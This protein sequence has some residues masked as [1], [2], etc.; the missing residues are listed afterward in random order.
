MKLKLLFLFL[1]F[2]IKSVFAQAPFITTWEVTADDLDIRIPANTFDGRVF[3][4][5]INF[6]DGTIVN[7]V[8]GWITHTY[9]TPGIYTVEIS[10]VFP[11]IITWAL[12]SGEANQLKSI[13]QWGDIEWETMSTAFAFC[14]NMV[15]NAT[16]APDLSQTTSLSSMFW[17]AESMNSDINH[18]DVSTITNMSGLFYS[19]SSFNQPLNN[20][21]V[22]NVVSM[23]RMFGRDDVSSSNDDGMFNQPLNN[24][25]VTNVTDM[26]K[27][28]YGNATFNQ[29]ISMWNV[30]NVQNMGEMFADTG[31][32]DQPLNSWNV[33]NVTNMERMFGNATAFN[34]S[35]NSWN[36]SNVQNMRY[37]FSYT[38][39]FNGEIGNWDVSGI[40]TMIGMF[41]EA[42]AFNQPIGDWNVINVLSMESTFSGAVAF[43]QPIDNWDVDNVTTMS[44][45]FQEAAAFNQS[46]N[47]WNIE[48]VTLISR[49]FKDATSFNGAIDNWTFTST[50]SLS[51][52]FENASSF[53]QPLNN[54]DVTN[55]T[56]MSSMFRGASAFNQPLPN[57]NVTNLQSAS[58]MFRDATSFNQPLDSWNL[59]TVSSLGSFLSNTNMSVDNYDLFLTHLVTLNRSNLSL[60]ATGLEYC[61]EGARMVLV[62]DLGWNISGDSLAEACN[63]LSG[64]ILYDANGNGCDASE[65]INANIFVDV[66]NN[67]N[68]FNY[69]SLVTNGSYSIPL[70]G[71]SF[72]VSL[73]NLPSYFSVTPDPATISFSGTDMQE[74]DFCITPTQ[75]VEDLNIV[76]IPVEAARPGFTANYRLVVENMGT[77]TIN[78]I[79]ATLSFDDAMQ[80]FVSAAPT[81]V[82]TTSNT[83]EFTIPTLQPLDNTSIEITMQTLPPPTVNSDDIL[84]FTAT[85]LPTANE[86]TPSDNTYQ[87][88]QTVVN[89]FDPN[90]KQVLE[91][92]TITIVEAGEY[93]NYLIRFQNTGTASAINVRIVDVLDAKLD[94]DTMR[95]TSASHPYTARIEDEYFAVFEFENINLPAQ[96][97]DEEGSNGFISFKIKP[98]TNVQIGD[99]I[100]GNAYIFFDFNA[101]II[102][103]T[104]NTEIVQDDL[105]V[106]ENTAALFTIYPSIATTEI[107]VQGKTPINFVT[108]CDI[109]GRLLHTIQETGNFNTNVN[110]SHLAK[111]MYFMKILS[112][113]G[114]QTFKFIK[115]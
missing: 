28:F 43:N 88:A 67:D 6:G 105:S 74:V 112:E 33:M 50:S 37:M 46:L 15:I 18:W 39:A 73:L 8:D 94:W 55:I 14:R 79:T 51:S 19:A 114:K 44:K 21:N 42:L 48:N 65:I 12:D 69:A 4:Y 68:S 47:S 17:E 77:T 38:D 53:N 99:I 49:M 102:T 82:N 81:A 59:V 60:G 24:W 31:A 113:K 16:D 29:D 64:T 83:L 26:E 110:V 76:L 97:V 91:G 71:E 103:N 84:N 34:Q 100:S 35:L 58:F 111:G 40:T 62:D 92:A 96:V 3:D 108:I 80:S 109:N 10:G 107:V 52:L 54:W 93:L 5:T 89:S 95:I 56:S 23:A 106:A 2:T 36:V 20:W 11:G 78:N 25:N 101:P 7:N 41:Q 98:R 70:S 57:W 30:I 61:N 115:K 86:N 90:D 72:S 104:V 9:T 22:S 63:T 66:N 27:M 1:L 32:F 85:V 13:E 87:L 75:M 45:M